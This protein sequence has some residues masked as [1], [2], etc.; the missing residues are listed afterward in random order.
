MKHAEKE[1]LKMDRIY[2]EMLKKGWKEEVNPQQYAMILHRVKT[3]HGYDITVED[4]HLTTRNL[5]S[6]CKLIGCDWHSDKN[7]NGKGGNDNEE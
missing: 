5:I 7:G 6:I 1:V 4:A 3:W 2:Q